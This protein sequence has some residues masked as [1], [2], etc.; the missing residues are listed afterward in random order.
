[1]LDRQSEFVLTLVVGVIAAA[2]WLSQTVRAIAAEGDLSAKG[3]FVWVAAALAGMAI[4]V[5]VGM[6]TTGFRARQAAR[7]M[8]RGGPNAVWDGSRYALLMG[9]AFLGWGTGPIFAE[10]QQLW[11]W[12]TPVG[13]TLVAGFALG[14]GVISRE[15]RRLPLLPPPYYPPSPGYGPASGYGPAPG[16]GPAAPGGY[17]P[18]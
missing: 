10:P 8:A 7:Q 9:I 13:M 3:L 15:E 5:V 18:A 1:M 6:L 4:G 11:G 14:V 16:Y 2:T 12:L 17:P